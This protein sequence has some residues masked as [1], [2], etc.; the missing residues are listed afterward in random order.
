MEDRVRRIRNYV[1]DSLRSQLPVMFKRWD[2]RLL[3]VGET[4]ARSVMEPAGTIRHALTAAAR[5][6]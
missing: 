6:R 5:A 1:V 4:L 2:F 3:L